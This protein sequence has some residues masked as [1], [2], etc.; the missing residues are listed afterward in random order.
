[1]GRNYLDSLEMSLLGLS[2][3]FMELMATESEDMEFYYSTLKT[4]TYRFLDLVNRHKPTGDEK[5]F[6]EA[7][8]NYDPKK[9]QLFNNAEQAFYINNFKAYI[10]DAVRKKQTHLLIQDW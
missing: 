10:E 8:A 3:K 5:S 1:M 2:S 7:L 6:L 9:D 4:G